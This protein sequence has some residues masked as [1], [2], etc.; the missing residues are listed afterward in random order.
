M[1]IVHFFLSRVII[2]RGASVAGWNQANISHDLFMYWRCKRTSQLF[3]LLFPL[4]SPLPSP[5]PS[6]LLLHIYSLYLCCELVKDINQGVLSNSPTL[7]FPP[8]K[9]VC[10]MQGHILLT[11]HYRAADGF[12]GYGFDKD[13]TARGGMCVF[14]YMNVCVWGG[15]GVGL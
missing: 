3:L 2:L 6:L 10:L 5:S 4:L 15:K 14:L 9:G 1:P 11:R 7:P 8:H 12:D 13:L